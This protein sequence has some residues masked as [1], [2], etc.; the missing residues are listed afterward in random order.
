MVHSHCINS[1]PNGS[2]LHTCGTSTGRGGQPSGATVGMSQ[3]AQRAT[4]PAC[5]PARRRVHTRPRCSGV[6]GH[7]QRLVLFVVALLVATCGLSIRPG[8]AQAPTEFV[9]STDHIPN[10]ARNPTIQS[11]QNGS[12][13]ATSTWS[14][15]R[16]PQPSDR[17]LIRHTITYNT[18]NGNVD[19]VGIDAAGKLSFAVGVN[20]KLRV[21][22]LLVMPGGTL[23]VGT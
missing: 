23:E 16:I 3:R 21:G 13:E 5:Q 14:P 4:L 8:Q 20:T 11:V 12:W 10:F 17:V 1:S 2:N 18:T 7:G 19:T 9:V 22:T 15:A 6:S